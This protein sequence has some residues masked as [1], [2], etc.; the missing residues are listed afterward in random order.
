[1]V[2]LGAGNAPVVIKSDSKNVGDIKSQGLVTVPILAKI[3]SNASMGEYQ[4]PLT[5]RYTYLESANE[6]C[7]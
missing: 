5:I 4:I 7:G 6:R 1:M 3:L 2:G